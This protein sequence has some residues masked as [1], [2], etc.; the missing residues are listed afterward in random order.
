VDHLGLVF[1][2]GGG[3]R[4]PRGQAAAARRTNTALIASLSSHPVK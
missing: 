2:A 3:D 4:S 1:G